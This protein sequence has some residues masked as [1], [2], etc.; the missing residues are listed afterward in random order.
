M[1]F[2]LIKATS[3]SLGSPARHEPSRRPALT[4]GVVQVAWEAD[5]ATHI[6]TICAGVQLAV[7][8][9]A[10]VVCL[11]ELTLSP[12]FAATEELAQHARTY[13]EKVHGGPTLTM[14]KRLAA[15]TGAVIH[16][17]LFEVGAQGS[18][19]YNTAICVDPDGRLLART[20]KLHIPSFPGYREDLCFQPGDTGFPVA[21][22]AGAK[23][24]FPT[25]WDQWFP[26]VARAYSLS[27]AEVLVY[28]TAIGSEPYLDAFD[29]Q[30]MW[31]QM[32]TA[33]GLAN[34]TFMVVANRIGEEN[35][36]EFY[37]SSFVSD[38]YGRVL[39]EAPRDRAA[40]L[41]AELD[42]DHRRDWLTFGLLDTR[43]PEL[44]KSLVEP[45]AR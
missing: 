37:G 13:A 18:L 4:V 42:L 17:S 10:Q 19:G 32:I 27:G 5:A 6:S 25:C 12:Y 11:Q 35:G 14:A 21:D 1:Q 41:V 34:A 16:A 45:V 28:P 39:V 38:P 40:V 29:T 8:E 26:E 22:V 36:M 33:N 3:S 43:R 31:R 15:S 23:F 2:E 24:G 7:D 20:R 30:P 9:G 44:Y